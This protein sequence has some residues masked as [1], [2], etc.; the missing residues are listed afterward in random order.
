MRLLRKYA[1]RG[2]HPRPLF[3]LI[4]TV[5]PSGLPLRTAEGLQDLHASVGQAAH[6]LDSGQQAPSLPT[7]VYTSTNLPIEHLIRTSGLMHSP[8]A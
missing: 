7:P 8:L 3:R 6:A 5:K 2:H 1:T 4:R